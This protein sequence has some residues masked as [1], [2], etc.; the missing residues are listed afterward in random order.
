[1]SNHDL[2]FAIGAVRYLRSNGVR[3]AEIH[4]ALCTQLGCPPEAARRL[5]RDGGAS[6]AGR[7]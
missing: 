5:A 6:I 3:T 1:M 2:E 4:R 7:R